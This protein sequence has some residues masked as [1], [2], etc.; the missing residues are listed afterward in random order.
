MTRLPE[1]RHAEGDT[2]AMTAK[3]YPSLWGFGTT[4]TFKIPVEHLDFKY[5]EKCSD[6]KHLEKIFCVLRSGEEGYYPELTEFCEKRLKG[7]APESRA[8]R[9]DK[10]AATASSFTA[11]EWEKIDGDIKSWISEI[12]KEENKMHFH[13]TETLPAKEDNLPPVRGSRSHLHVSKEKYSN[14]R[15]PKKKIPR[16]YAEWDKFDV[17]KECSKI[18][19]DYKEKAVVN[20]KSHLS[21]IETRIDTAGLTEKE[22]TFLATHEKEKGNEAFHSGDYEEA[23]MYYTRSI[24]VLPTVAAYNNRAQAELKLQNWNS[25]FQDCE[26]VLELEPGNLKALLRRATTYKHQNKLQE[27][28]EDLNKVLNVEPDN[29]LA[30]KTL[31]EVERDLKNSEPASKTQTK[32]KRLVIQE[33]ENSE[34]EGGKDSRRA[35]EDGRGDK[36]AAEPAGAGSAAEPRAMGNIQKKLTGKSEGG[37]RPERGALRRGRAPGAGADKRGRPR[38]PEAAGS[39]SRHP[40]SGRGAGDPAAVAAAPVPAATLGPADLK[41]QGNE[42]F[43]S[44][45]F[46]EAA[47]K[48]SAAIAQLEPA[49]SGSADDLSVLYSNRAAC[50]LKEGNCSGCIQD[51][52]RALELHPFSVKPLLRRAM[53][54]ETLEQY[55]KAY[56]DYKIVL[57]IDC[58][59]QL[60]NDSINRITRILMNLDGPSWREKLS[61]IPAVPTSAHLRA[62]QPV[63]ETPPNQGGGSCSRP[64]PGI[65]D[66]KMFKTLKEE[67]NQCVKDKNYKDALSKYSECLKIN[68]KECAIYTNR[69]LCYLKLCQFEEAKQDCD[70][71]LQIDNGNVKACYRRALAHKGLK[72][73]QKSLNDLNKVLLLDSSIVEAKMELEEVTRFLNIKDNT[74]LFN[75]EK[76]RRKIEIQEV[77]E[78]Q[79]EE[80]GR[81][82]EELSTDCRASENGDTTSSGPPEYSEKLP[83]TKPNNAYEF[84]QVINAFSMR[85]DKQA[86]AHL[87]T[88]TEPKDLPMLLSNKLEG[89]TFLLL[90]QSLKNNL[91]KDP[92]LVYQHLLYL[93]KVERFMMMLTLISKGQKKQ[94]EQLFDDLSDTP[95]K[96]F[97]LEDVQALKRKYEL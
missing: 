76:E 77:S 58:R 68:N 2:F 78:G 93:S 97:T 61:P 16:D 70:R 64:L 48:Y 75:K 9:K 47:L 44:G 40:G 5:I 83:I 45:Q 28:L 32:G 42:L 24:S 72:D 50:Y 25:A 33:V 8:L 67:G 60:A 34:D 62:W 4:K 15:R 39:A 65:T 81:T 89:D 96:H 52:N 17:E 73:Y 82:S 19:E 3:D 14:S 20:N 1:G 12:K 51:C 41:S 87:L 88:I 55:Q 22:K 63:A 7:L 95:N 54:Y 85:N 23:V 71:A 56:V 46:A 84:G 21:K 13:E 74:T 26:K 79:E 11:E 53:A 36:Q 92:S 30:K 29:E 80:P 35:Q 10:P 43:K 94:I 59:I 66:E 38:A 57:Q 49:G 86:C 91:G 31:S 37:K 69:A 18:D 27:A 90:I 6:V